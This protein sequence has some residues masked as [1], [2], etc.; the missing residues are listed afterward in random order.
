[1][2]KSGIY[3][4]IAERTGG[5]IYIGVVGPVRTGKSTFIKRFMETMVIPGIENVYKKERAKDE[6]PQSGSGR[7]IMT[8]EPKFVPEEAA[9]LHLPDGGACKIRLVDCVGYLI[10]GAMGH[11]EG[12]KPRMVSTPWNPEP[13][14]MEQAAETGTA[15]VIR[16]HST[17]GLVITT[18]GSVTEFDRA[19]YVPAEKRVISELQKIQKPF[20]VVLNTQDPQSELAQ[21]TAE[22]IRSAYQVP[23]MAMN[24]QT[25]GENE[26]R[27]VLTSVLY[28]FPVKEMEIR[29]PGW[30][31]SLPGE[32]PVK[33]EVYDGI[34]QTASSI[35]KMRDLPRMQNGKEIPCVSEV[36]QKKLYLGEGRA[37]LVFV[38]PPQVFYQIAG[39]ETGLP[40]RDEADLIPLLRELSQIRE[41]YQRFA[42]AL[43]QVKQTGYGIVM[44]TI[45]EMILAEP[46]IIKQGGRYG[47]KLSATA[48]SIHLIRANIE[49]AVTPIVGSEK[50][51]EELI[52]YLL[53]DFHEDPKKIW[54]SNIFGKS[55]QE[56]VGEGLHNKLGHMPEDARGKLQETLEKIINEGSG[57]LICILL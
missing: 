10:E 21:K 26:V 25:L 53:S 28:E 1:M 37:E 5:D 43:E 35:Q 13:I 50:Q 57:G 52:A 12:D 40:I 24:C 42:G 32:H 29:L 16:E 7:T 55:L 20:L 27:Q 33:K 15:K 23:V 30:I 39:E 46:E 38:I 19:A 8:A 4:E 14:P 6:L 18:D 34:L 36:E 56:L 11:Q 54:D 3:Q 44:P 45:E 47:V 9:E 48:P 49:T 51:S 17:I 41:Q 2:Q 31:S 22:E